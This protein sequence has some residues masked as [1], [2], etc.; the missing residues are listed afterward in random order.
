MLGAY[1]APNKTISLKFKETQ[2]PEVA[3]MEV[4]FN[5]NKINLSGLFLYFELLNLELTDI[6]KNKA[7][8]RKTVLLQLDISQVGSGPIFVALLTQNRVL[9]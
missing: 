8:M 5:E 1:Y 9:A 6:F 7:S 4:F 2:V 3:G